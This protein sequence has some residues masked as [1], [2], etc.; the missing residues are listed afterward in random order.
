MKSKAV[1][2]LLPDLGITKTHSRPH[3]SDDNPYSESHFKTLKYRPDFSERFGCI[4]DVRG[5]SGDFFRWY[6]DEH[7]HTGL[8]LLTPA[9]VHWGRAEQRHADRTL[10]LA[11]A[12]RGHPERFVLGTPAP[13][14]LPTAA[15]INKPTQSERS[16]SLERFGLGDRA[17][18]C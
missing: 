12:H 10:V 8:G 15:W 3:V 9:D 16:L 2:F 7:H 17:A 4:E 14:P 11:A 1:A 5:F 18:A 6:N 13:P